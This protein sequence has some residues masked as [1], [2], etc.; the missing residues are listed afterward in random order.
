[1]VGQIVG[2]NNVTWIKL[3]LKEF[4]RGLGLEKAR[5]C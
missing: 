5:L 3:F 2:K 4:D 1:M